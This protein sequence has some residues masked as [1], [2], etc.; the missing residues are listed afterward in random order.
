M[1]GTKE[2]LVTYVYKHAGKD[3]FTLHEIGGRGLHRL[4]LDLYLSFGQN[5]G[6]DEKIAQNLS[7][8]PIQIK[9]RLP[10]FMYQGRSMNLEPMLVAHDKRYI[11]SVGFT[12]RSNI[13]GPVNISPARTPI[14][15][16]VIDGVKHL[17]A[18]MGVKVGR[19]GLYLH[20]LSITALT[21][22]RKGLTW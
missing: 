1:S 11:H 10:S 5:P 12:I 19:G 6:E 9:D 13:P 8:L 15:E 17:H 22:Q 3:L 2:A 18:A 16:A 7:R 14:I 4:G 20:L 21:A